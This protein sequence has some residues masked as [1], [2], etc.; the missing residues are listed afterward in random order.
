MNRR[1]TTALAV[2]AGLAAGLAGVEARAKTAPDLSTAL[3]RIQVSDDPL[4]PTVV[5]STERVAP[6]TRG[7]LA[8]R[9]NDNHLQALVDRR[10][11]EVRYE[12]KQTVQ[13][14]GGFRDF[15]QANYQ[16]STG[17]GIAELTPLDNNRIHCEATLEIQE[18]CFE[19]VSFTVPEDTLR[20]LASGA[21]EGWQFKFKPRFG[22]EH[23]AQMSRTEIQA[24]LQA[25][26]THRER[27]VTASI[28]GQP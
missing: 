6:S 16:A 1:H 27:I 4:E 2:M 26:D 14:V 12:L 9:Y 7:I 3:Q 17:L 5:I 8:A 19:V 18:A 13:Y 10:T 22:A 23:R 15:Q 20:G 25:V 24:L 21:G 28:H 11:G